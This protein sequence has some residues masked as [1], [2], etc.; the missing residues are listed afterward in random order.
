MGDWEVA[1]RLW[2]EQITIVR[3]SPTSTRQTGEAGGGFFL[4]RGSQ[5]TGTRSEVVT[6]SHAFQIRNERYERQW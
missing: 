4:S 2:H 1:S 6:V 3:S 5:D